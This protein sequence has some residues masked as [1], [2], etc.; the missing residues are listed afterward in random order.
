MGSKLS[1]IQGVEKT[2]YELRM[3]NKKFT[4]YDF[5]FT[6]LGFRPLTSDL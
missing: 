1:T 4:I 3:K 2:N 5:R 6:I